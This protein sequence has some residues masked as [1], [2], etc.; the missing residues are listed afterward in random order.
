M[1]RREHR[2]RPPARHRRPYV[3]ITT[4]DPE[5]ELG[6]GA[7]ARYA[8][9]LEAANAFAQ[10]GA[11]FKQ[12]VWDDGRTMRWLDGR[13]QRLLAAVCQKLGYDV[14]DAG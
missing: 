4:S 5:Q 3:L 13:E 10:T 8:T 1:R 2:Y 12:V 11:P 14:E 7:K 9:M 6:E